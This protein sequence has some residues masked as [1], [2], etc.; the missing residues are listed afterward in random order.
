MTDPAPKEGQS[1]Q[2][3]DDV[4]AVL[5][6]HQEALVLLLDPDPDS[7]GESTIGCFMKLGEPSRLSAYLP[8]LLQ[9]LLKI[10]RGKAGGNISAQAPTRS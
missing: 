4:K 1:Q 5:N 6:G 8:E 7:E 3:S 9:Q 2:P 10:S